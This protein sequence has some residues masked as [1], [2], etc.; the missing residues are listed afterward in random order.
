MK[1]E[2]TTNRTTRILSVIFGLTLVAGLFMYASTFISASSAFANENIV[3]KE[4]PSNY[5]GPNENGMCN[6]QVTSDSIRIGKQ[7]SMH[8]CNVGGDTIPSNY[9]LVGQVDSSQCQSEGLYIHNLYVEQELAPFFKIV[10]EK[11]S[12]KCKTGAEKAPENFTL[13]GNVSSSQCQEEGVYAHNLYVA[14]EFAPYFVIAKD[15]GDQRCKTG[16]DTVS[17]NFTLV[18]KVGSSQCQEEGLYKHNLYVADAFPSTFKNVSAT[19]P[20]GYTVLSATQCTDAKP[21]EPKVTQ[22]LSPV[23]VPVTKKED[24]SKKKALTTKEIS[25]I[26]EA[27]CTSDTTEGLDTDKD[28]ISDDVEKILGTNPNT[29]DTDGD[30]LP[31]WFELCGS[32]TNPNDMDTNNDKTMDN[33]ENPDKDHMTNLVEYNQGTHPLVYNE[34]NTDIAVVA[35]VD[36]SIN[37]D[38]TNE[39][40]EVDKPAIE[41]PKPKNVEAAPVSVEKNKEVV[42]AIKENPTEEVKAIENVVTETFSTPVQAKTSQPAVIN[43]EME[44]VRTGGLSLSALSFIGLSGVSAFTLK[45]TKKGKLKI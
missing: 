18:G 28:Y 42:T 37:I 2:I 27:V 6:Y 10:K 15:K 11:G 8:R 12:Q 20:E 7:R 9:S 16:G 30:S 38:N 4:C 44:T 5:A 3:S 17:E 41:I 29:N 23:P 26:I 21:A 14:D 33:M 25:S 24:A 1:L 39:V 32:R 31:D 19:C 34:E 35:Q 36:V 45:E 40:P 43:T 13:I 22:A